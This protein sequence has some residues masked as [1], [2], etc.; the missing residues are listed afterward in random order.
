MGMR[1]LPDLIRRKT[2]LIAIGQDAPRPFRRMAARL[3]LENQ[4]TILKGRDDIPRFLLG[5]DLLVHPAYMENTGTVILEA[6]VAGLP[7][8]ATDVCGYAKH[9]TDANAGRLVCSPY[10]QSDFNDML[11]DMMTS[12]ERQAWKNN[13]LA[14][15]KVAD[16]YSMPERA[17]DL[18]TSYIQ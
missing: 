2:R 4:V 6:I 14:Y 17:A 13:G 9:V 10:Q 15:S 12:G 7:V 11:L 3:R 1:A 5:A 8:L 18:I 16:I